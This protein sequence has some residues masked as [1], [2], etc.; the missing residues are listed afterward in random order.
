ML[1]FF[2]ACGDKKTTPN[3][4]APAQPTPEISEQTEPDT[5]SS[6][7]PPPPKPPKM[8]NNTE[9]LVKQGILQPLPEQH[10]GSEPLLVQFNTLYPN[11]CWM[12]TEAAHEI[13]P[14]T[15]S[16]S[17]SILHSYTT[18]YEGEGRMCTMGFKPGGFK[19]ELSLTPGTYNGRIL[20][21]N[22]ERTTYSITIVAQ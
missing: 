17:G 3:T 19:T 15:D 20:V 21:D 14:P 7:P 12:Q 8:Q 2:M 9:I 13:T 16:S 18:S 10:T 11:G 1:I 6:A 4:P 5:P 22:E